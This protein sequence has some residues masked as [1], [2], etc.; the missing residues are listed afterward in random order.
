MQVAGTIV[1]ADVSGA[2]D[3]S[4]GPSARKE[5]G[6]QDDKADDAARFGT[7]STV[8]YLDSPFIRFDLYV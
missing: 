4:I 1:K 5:R 8:Y 2:A 7:I 3:E 6:P